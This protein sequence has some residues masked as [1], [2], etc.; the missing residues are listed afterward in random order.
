MVLLFTKA[1]ANSRKPATFEKIIEGKIK[2]LCVGSTR[3][4]F[5]VDRL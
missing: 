1:E 4:A 5:E 2:H 3:L